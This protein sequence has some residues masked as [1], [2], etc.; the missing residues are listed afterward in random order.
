MKD[1]NHNRNASS[2]AAQIFAGE[3]EMAELMRARDWSESELGP[4][5]C[6]PESLKS[7]LSICLNS[8]FP[9]ALYWGP[10]FNLLYNDAWRPIPGD[11]HP[12]SLG[13]KAREVWPEIWDTIGPMFQ[14]V[15]ET[16]K[17]VWSEDSLLP[18]HRFG[19]GRVLFQLQRQPSQRERWD[20]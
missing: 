14:S 9:F 7:T 13:R 4:L 6:W 19:S 8:R 15:R 16:G 20:R 2:L 5:E 1:K 3:G 17:G 12:Q 18:M 11:K 10:D